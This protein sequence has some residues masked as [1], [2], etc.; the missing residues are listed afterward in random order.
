MRSNLDVAGHF[1]GKG[2]ARSANIEQTTAI[3]QWIADRERLA[4]HND[5]RVAGIDDDA[6]FADPT[7]PIEDDAEGP[8]GATAPIDDDVE[9]DL[10]AAGMREAMTRLDDDDR[11]GEEELRRLVG[12]MDACERGEK[13]LQRQRFE[14]R[15]AA[16]RVRREFREREES[17]QRLRERLA[18]AA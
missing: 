4:V 11:R 3:E 13:E 2:A 8:L 10:D 16:E 1:F 17:R 5:G 12:V 7:P 18:H 6:A 15:D 9:M 14:A